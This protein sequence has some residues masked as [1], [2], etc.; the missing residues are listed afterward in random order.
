MIPQTFVE[1]ED[2]TG[3]IP[4]FNVTAAEFESEGDTTT[5]GSVATATSTS[6]TSGASSASSASSSSSGLSAGA[7]AGIAVGVIAGVG[8]LAAIGIFL[9]ARKRRSGYLERR[10]ANRINAPIPLNK[11]ST[12]GSMQSS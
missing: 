4:C 9:Y 10:R 12:A 11:H 6:S 5:T 1:D 2:F 8:S 3:Q 7:K